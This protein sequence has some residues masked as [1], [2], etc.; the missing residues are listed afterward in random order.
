[1]KKQGRLEAWIT[2]Y[3]IL[4]RNVP[5]IPLVM[6]VVSVILMNLLANK[7][8][9]MHFSWLALDCGFTVSWMSF[10]FM[11]MLTKRFGAKAAIKISLTAMVINLF[12]CLGLYLISIIPGNWAAFYDSENTI[13]NDALN[14]TFGGTW[15]VVLG[16]ALAFACSAIV[17]AVLN[18]SIGAKF[19]RN[20]FIAYAVRSYVSTLTAQ[21]VDNFIFATF[22]GHVFFGW[23]MMQCFTCS[24]TGCI[25]ELLC[26]VIISPYGYKVCK[27][28]EASGVGKEYIKWNEAKGV[29]FK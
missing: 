7:E 21:F 9:D 11:D 19:K 22:V 23:T 17:N 20:N 27:A 25:V 1:M 18:E 3:K 24:L 5:A 26:E 4:M 16:S 28:W 13:V 14:S 29:V 2:D 12:V 8:I 15:Y 6:F 10:L